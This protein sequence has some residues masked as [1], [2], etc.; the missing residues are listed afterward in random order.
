MHLEQDPN[1]DPTVPTTT[2]TTTITVPGAID[3]SPANSNSNP[4][5]RQEITTTTT[6]NPVKTKPKYLYFAY[7]SN[8]SP[9][10]MRIR[11]TH[12][13]SLSAHPVAI[14]ALDSW[15]WL[16]CQFGYANVVPPQG[17]R[18]GPEIDEGDDVPESVSK[19]I[20]NGGV[21]GVL[22]EMSSEDERI[23][24]GYEGVDHAA[25]PSREE[26]KVPTSVRPDDQGVGN[27]NKWYV[28][29]RVVEW[30]DGGYRGRNGFE[31]VGGEVRVLVYVDEN[32]VRVARPND[33]YVPRMNRAIRE[34]VSIGFP[35]D[36]AVE[37]MRRAIPE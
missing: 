31:G 33:E 8:L 10:Q 20:P 16:I 22:Y 34:A 7:G 36:W 15:R 26:D 11:C 21:Y 12:D 17:L 19:S 24:D 23:L 25:G 37:V 18:V 35:E 5:V 9:T 6:Q 4:H 27:Y 30:L 1:Q 14:A 29:A 13:P 32:R 28:G 3:P 2:I